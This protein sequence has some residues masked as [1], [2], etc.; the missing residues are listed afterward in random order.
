MSETLLPRLGHKV[1]RGVGLRDVEVSS[2]AAAGRLGPL[3]GRHAGLVVVH[4]EQSMPNLLLNLLK[5]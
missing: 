4:G 1:C 3:E 2:H 5:N